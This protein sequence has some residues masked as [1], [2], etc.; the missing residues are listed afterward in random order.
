MFAELC[1]RLNDI[2]IPI[3]RVSSAMTT[4]HPLNEA[5]TLVWTRDDGNLDIQFHEHRS[6]ESDDWK[7]S[8]L[9]ALIDSGEFEERFD[10][11]IQENLDR[12]PLFIDLAASGITEY[13]AFLVPF[14]NRFDELLRQD[15]MMLSWSTDHPGG[16]TDEHIRV[17]KR[18]IPRVGIVAK[19]ASRERI[20]FN[21]L[22]AYL[23]E[24]SGDQVLNGQIKLGDGQD[25]RAVIWFS[26]LRDSTPLAEK[27]TRP[28]FL[29]LLNDYFDSLAG[30]VMEHGGEVLRFIG[31]AALAI[32]PIGENGFSEDEARERAINAASDAL[33]RAKE[34]NAARKAVGKE[35]FRYGIGLHVGEIMYGNIGVP[36]RVEFSV[37][38]AA[39]NEAARL[40]GLT[41]ELKEVVLVSGEFADGLDYP[42][43]ALG[44]HPIKGSYRPMSIFAPAARTGDDT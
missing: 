40:E 37:I 17:L 2:G 33:V 7:R 21:I 27:L 32:F 15:G 35:P 20:T 31:D 26:D 5:V 30:A 14:T 38:G 34:R 42:W 12:Y 29:E 25:I 28:E 18:L 11:S 44:E 13:M 4:L 36:S 39:A 23:G 1:V 19:L 41:K 8:P 9:K 16:F 3:A 24:K 10:L 22:Y 6:S 43:R